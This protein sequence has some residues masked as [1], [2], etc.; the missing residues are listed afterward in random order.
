[1][2]DLTPDADGKPKAR[3]LDLVPGR[4]GKAYSDWLEERGEEFR[5]G[6]QVATLDP[7][8]GYKTA[9]DD[10]LE[11]ATAVLDAFH[12]VKLGTAAVVEVRRRVQQ[13]IHG[14]RGRKNDPLYGI[15]T[16]L[17]CGQEK[18][19]DSVLDSIGRSPPTNATTRSTSPGSAPNS[20]GRPTRP[21][22]PSRAAGSPRRYSPRC[23][24]V[25]SRRSSDSAEPSSSGARR[26][27]PTSTPAE[28]PTEAPKPS[29]DSSNST[30]ASHAASATASTTGYA[31]SSSA[32]D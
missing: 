17:R 27:W 26:S 23:R 30:A 10:Q 20:C 5:G 19:T 11:D 15:R 6:V 25:R 16:I 2:V 29:T 8:H 12:I 32:A 18:L 28:P 31:C 21:R 24:P 9:I 22:T 1:M 14:H 13:Q 7:F 3:L 4:S